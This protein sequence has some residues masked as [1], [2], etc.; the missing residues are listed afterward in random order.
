MCIKLEKVCSKNIN[1]LDLKINHDLKIIKKR[2]Q[3]I[4]DSRKGDIHK[5]QKEMKEYDKRWKKELMNVIN[6][7]VIG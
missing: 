4:E 6:K 3:A 2:W 5:T 1:M 7:G